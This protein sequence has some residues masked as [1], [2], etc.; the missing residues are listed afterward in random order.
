[1][2]C[3]A[4]LAMGDTH[5]V[6]FCQTSLA[7]VLRSSRLRLRDF[8]TLK[9]RPPRAPG[10]IAGLLIDDLL[11]LDFVA[12]KDPVQ[13]SLGS[14]VIDETRAGYEAAGIPRHAGKAV[15]AAPIGECW[16]GLLDGVEGILKPN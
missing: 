2:P 10:L 5:A 12:K 3:L 6:G 9:G 14:V 16:G 13:P 1:M 15:H 8:V 11:I 7:C 4:F